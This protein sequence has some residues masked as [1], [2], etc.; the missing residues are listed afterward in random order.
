MTLWLEFLARNL[1]QYT[2]LS[3]AH[4]SMGHR[5]VTP[6]GLTNYCH[7]RRPSGV[8]GKLLD[9]AAAAAAAALK[10]DLKGVAGDGPPA[11]GLETPTQSTWRDSPW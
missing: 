2:I 3:H 9:S 4:R 10:L 11:T 6:P 5:F 8:D 7:C 1:D